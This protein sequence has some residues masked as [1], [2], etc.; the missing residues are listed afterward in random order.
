MLTW[1]GRGVAM[2]QGPQVVHDAAD[3]VTAPVREDGA[4]IELRRWFP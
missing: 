2:G 4:A 1:A 3:H